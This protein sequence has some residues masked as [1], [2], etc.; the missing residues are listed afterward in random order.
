MVLSS[1]VGFVGSAPHLA[2]S[3]SAGSGFLG[4]AAAMS[5]S[6]G[7]T[8]GVAGGGGGSRGT[9]SR[10]AR[11][12]ARRLNMSETD[13]ASNDVKDMTERLLKQA[14]AARAEVSTHVPWIM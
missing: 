10:S 4:S 14:A 7:S 5:F 13:S 12:F 1:T 6:G 11:V 3:F 9:S 8:T 2:D